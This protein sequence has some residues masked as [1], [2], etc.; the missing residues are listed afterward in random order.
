MK[1][2][3]EILN[4]LTSVLFAQQRDEDADQAGQPPITPAKVPPKDPGP[5]ALPSESTLI[6]THTFRTS[7]WSRAKAAMPGMAVPDR[8]KHWYS[9]NAGI[10]FHRVPFSQRV[11]HVF[12]PNRSQ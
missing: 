10:D 11:I 2:R 12:T 9:G 5:Q 3:F 1:V 8:V 7:V 6:A 4:G